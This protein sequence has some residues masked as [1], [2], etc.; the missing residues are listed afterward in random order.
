MSLIVT[1]PP[2]PP[3]PVG[4]YDSAS[5]QFLPS[6]TGATPRTVQEALREMQTWQT[7]ETVGTKI[8]ENFPVTAGFAPFQIHYNSFAN[9]GVGAGT[10]NHATFLG[11][12]VNRHSSTGTATSNKPSL[13][14]G[15]E[16]NYYDDGGDAEYGME[17]YIEYYSPDGTSVQLL[18]PFYTRIGSDQNTDKHCTTIFQVGTDGVGQFT[19]RTDSTHTLFQVT[20]SSSA[21]Q[22]AYLKVTGGATGTGPVIGALGE[23][24]TPLSLTSNGTG[25]IDLMTGFTARIQF[26][27]ADQASSVNY[28]QITGGAT[29]AGPTLSAQGETNVPFNIAS[30][31]TGAINLITGGNA[32][33]SIS[34]TAS[35]V[36]KIYL[37]GGATAGTVQIAALGE[38]NAP[39]S[40]SSSGAGRID[41]LSGFFSNVQFRVTH[42]A[43]S[44]NFLSV[45]GAATGANPSISASSENLLFGSGSAI[46]TTATAGYVMF[47]SCAGTPTGV[48]TGQG[49]GKIPMVFDTTGVKLWFYTGGAWKGVVVA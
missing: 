12:N 38:T 41:F 45:T 2:V 31:G 43:S 30:S 25:R 3:S 47:P 18:R 15:M 20:P 48:P 21:A 4:L 11:Y 40:F 24:N 7:A 36:N 6:G 1:N 27:V 23:T 49:A 10:Y 32:Q 13:I 17:W 29:T 5:I 35:A 34:N 14:M 16:D 39:I 46:A 33:V 8:L 44:V 19:V 28:A 37:S 26:R 22:V 42:A 9:T